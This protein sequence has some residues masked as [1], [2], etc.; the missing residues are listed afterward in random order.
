M[1]QRPQEPVRRF[2]DEPIT[3]VY[4]RW[5]CPKCLG[6]MKSTGKGFTTMS[7]SWEHRCDS[8]G[9]E[10]WANCNYPRVAYLPIEA[11]DTVADGE[12]EPSR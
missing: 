5:V 2:R 10:E 7:T 4:R 8:C 12:K 3:T 9:H 11:I 1:T 6:E